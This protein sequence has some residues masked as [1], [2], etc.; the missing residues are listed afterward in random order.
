MNKHVFAL[1]KRAEHVGVNRVMG[2]LHSSDNMCSKFLTS[3][4]T[5]QRASPR[6]FN[7][8]KFPQKDYNWTINPFFSILVTTRR[9][10]RHSMFE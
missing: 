6:N 9:H 7:S 3:T 4:A 2:F 10:K 1:S 8:V 5:A